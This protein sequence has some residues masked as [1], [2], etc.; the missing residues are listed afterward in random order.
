MLLELGDDIGEV[1]RFWTGSTYVGIPKDEK[2][3]KAFQLFFEELMELLLDMKDS[4]MEFEKRVATAM[5]YRGTVYRYLGH[6]YLTDEV[7]APVYDN[8]YVSWNK[9]EGN[10]YILSKLHGPVTKMTCIIAEPLYGID[11]GI[12]ECCKGIECEV[13]FPTVEECVDEIKYL[14]SKNKKLIIE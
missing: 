4:K 10:A 8:I 11:L 2:I 12:L 14:G 1:C 7:V 6:N 13:V 3:K 5:L 9:E